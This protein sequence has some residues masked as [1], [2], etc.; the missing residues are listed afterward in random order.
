MS[1]SDREQRIVSTPAYMLG[2]SIS[3]VQQGIEKCV[4]ETLALIQGDA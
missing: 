4:Q 2:P 1:D 3:H